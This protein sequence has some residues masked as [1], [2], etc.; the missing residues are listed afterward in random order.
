MPRPSDLVLGL[1]EAGR[2]PILG[3]LVLACVA[4][5]PA[6]SAALT[7]AGV[8]DSKRFGAG[9]G[10][11]A[12]RCALLPRILDAAA[13]VAV[14]VVDVRDVDR[15]TRRG[16]LNRLEQERARG[17]IA[18]APAVRRIVADGAR[19]FGPLAH[20]HP[21]FDALDHGEDQ[22]VAV[23]AASVVAKVRRDE[24]YAKIAAR[25]A[26][27]FGP[28]VGGGYVNEGTRRFL[29]AYIERHGALPPEARRSWP[30]DFAR[31]LLGDDFDPLG[32]VPDDDPQRSLW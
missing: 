12:R 11:H 16:G 13:H 27:A 4:L 19:L 30:W 22:H 28:L 23:A 20:L 10:A 9:S 32:D 17:L 21:R 7:R 8:M 5:S 6:R 2:G 3:P 24:L 26:P 1:D 25:Y 18:A 31:D 15:Y 14:V 29:R